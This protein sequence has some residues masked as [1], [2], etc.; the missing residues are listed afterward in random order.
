[1]TPATPAPAAPMRTPSSAWLPAPTVPAAATPA[2][3]T[4]SETAHWAR[5]SLPATERGLCSVILGD[6]DASP[7]SRTARAVSS[8]EDRAGAEPRAATRGS[9]L[10]VHRA[11]RCARPAP[12]PARDCLPDARL[13]SA[14]PHSSRRNPH[15]RRARRNRSAN[16][17]AFRAVARA[18]ATNPVAVV[19]PCHRVIGSDGKATGY[20]WGMERKEET[21]ANGRDARKR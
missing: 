14:A 8:G 3:A 20:R 19:V 16:P 18:C 12:G 17:K 1:M 9:T 13:G 2:S 21:A 10:P 4:P 7:R 11:S 5:F 6:T 15:L